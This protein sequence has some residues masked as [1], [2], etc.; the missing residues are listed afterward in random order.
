MAATGGVLTRR[1]LPSSSNS[2]SVDVITVLK[3]LA[4]CSKGRLNYDKD[5]KPTVEAL[6][7]FS[8]PPELSTELSS[9][10]PSSGGIS[11]GEQNGFT[12]LDG[13]EVQQEEE[14][15]H[16]DFSSIESVS[17][18]AERELDDEGARSARFD[19]LL[20]KELVATYDGT[21]VAIHHFETEKK[22]QA[23]ERLNS[24]KD[25]FE[26]HCNKL[27]EEKHRYLQ[28]KETERV[29]E[30]IKS[31]Q[32]LQLDEK[33]KSEEARVRQQK[34]E[35]SH[36]EYA[37][38]AVRRVKEVEELRLKV[39][40]QEHLLEKQLMQLKASFSS[41]RETASDIQRIF[42][43]CKYKSSLSHSMPD[44]LR[45]VD[46]VLKVS[47]N[48]FNDAFENRQVTEMNVTIIQECSSLIQSM[49][50]KTKS[51]VQE[52][53][54]KAAKEEAE[55]QLRAKEQEARKEKERAEK[56]KAERAAR[57][58]QN[59]QA[60]T[61]AAQTSS[62]ASPPKAGLSKELSSCISEAAWKEYSRLVSYKS[63]IVK[64]AEPLNT[65]K[66]LKQ[67]KF[68]LQRAV[69]TPINSIS[70]ESIL[71]KIQRLTKFL[72]GGSVQVG[73]KQI[74]IAVHPAAQV[75]LLNLFAH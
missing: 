39:L 3:S 71:D 26:E 16:S 8:R 10:S 58:K 63:E 73:R 65:D 2:T 12:L 69:A 18:S 40:K 51:L 68:D 27:K 14:Q 21:D 1:N 44:I 34:L 64:A 19:E 35:Q 5:W 42:H 36:E 23:H 22:L 55:E 54:A 45:E 11:P 53:N 59:N 60:S 57:E 15:E 47:Q 46:K 43:E 24:R 48:T 32:A 61:S 62:S 28:Q 30:F 66:S 49:L 72:S 7:E 25:R 17:S 31:V 41:I 6:E 38:R 52:V 70:E 29:E 9:V 50:Q 37:Q 56:E 33:R 4:S 67:L 74:S 13:T 75:G 20:E